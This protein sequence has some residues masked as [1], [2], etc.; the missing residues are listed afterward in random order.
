[1]DPL[2]HTAAGVLLARAGLDRFTPRA[3]LICV[4]AANIPDI[5]VLTATSSINYL[6]YHRHL[7]HGLVAVPFMGA[8]AVLL[9]EGLAGLFGRRSKPLPWLRA[10]VVSTLVAF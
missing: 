7:T 4:V 1:M 9:A 10:W 5:D 3:T 6:N 8:L 2:T